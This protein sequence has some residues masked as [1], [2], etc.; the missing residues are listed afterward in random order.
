M[1]AEIERFFLVLLFISG[2]IIYVIQLNGR[3][4]LELPYSYL[5][6]IVK[7]AKLFVFGLMLI[8]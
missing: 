5:F 7:K 8:F 6:V 4:T 1:E 2:F 3:N